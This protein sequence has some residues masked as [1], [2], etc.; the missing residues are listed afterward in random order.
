MNGSN[1]WGLLASYSGAGSFVDLGITKAVA[2]E[3]VKELYDNLWV[4]RATRAVFLDFTTYNANLNL[5]CI[6]KLVPRI[7]KSFLDSPAF[8]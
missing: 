2:K 4:S 7:F 6:V 5:F 3:K 8:L 1:H